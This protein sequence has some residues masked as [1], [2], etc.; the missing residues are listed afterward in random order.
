MMGHLNFRENFRIILSVRTY[1]VG[2]TDHLRK[3]CV[4]GLTIG[5]PV[6]Q[7]VALCWGSKGDNVIRLFKRPECRI[8]SF[9]AQLNE[10]LDALHE[11]LLF[12]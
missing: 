6:I 12:R 8:G 11:V 7:R 3:E 10:P 9:V 4:S 5:G 1:E 2:N